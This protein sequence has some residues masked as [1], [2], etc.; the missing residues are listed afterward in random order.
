MIAMRAIWRSYLG[1]STG[2]KLRERIAA[3]VAHLREEHSSPTRLGLA[4]AVGLFIGTLPLYGLHLGICLAVAWATELNKVTVYAAANISNPVV[5]PFLVAMGI[6]IGEFIRFGELQPLDLEAS[7]T[8]IANL[9]LLGASLPDRFLS[10][11]LGDAVLGL[12]LALVFGPVT[13]L[14][15]RRWQEPTEGVG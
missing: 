6:V 11:L 13:V 4:V 3:L 12:V 14:A 8:F 15:A 2:A 1:P 9:S 7:A 5:A 10:C